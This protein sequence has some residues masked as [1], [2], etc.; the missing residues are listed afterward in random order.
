[1]LNQGAALTGKC[2]HPAT[3]RDTFIIRFLELSHDPLTLQKLLGSEDMM[4]E[5]Y[6]QLYK[7]HTQ[8]A[9]SHHD[10]DNHLLSTP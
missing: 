6:M 5:Y 1:M 2:L 8:D 10:T 9:Q 3:L 7:L 4:I